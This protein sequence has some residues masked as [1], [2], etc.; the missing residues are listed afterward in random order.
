MRPSGIKAKKGLAIS[1]IAFSPPVNLG[2]AFWT[3]YMLYSIG[4]ES[5]KLNVSLIISWV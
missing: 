2:T 4:T 5:K 3:E 1:G